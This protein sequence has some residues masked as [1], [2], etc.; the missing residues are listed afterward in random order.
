M[1]VPVNT[2]MNIRELLNSESEVVGVE[3]INEK[4]LVKRVLARERDG[5]KTEA[6]ETVLPFPPVE[7]QLP[8]VALCKRV[9]RVYATSTLLP[10]Q[11]SLL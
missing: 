9:C 11:H 7:K 6:L 3:K 4:S 8:A 1:V 10:S 2:Q 5:E